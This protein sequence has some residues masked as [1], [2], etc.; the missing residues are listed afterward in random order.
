MI[1]VA[2]A[3]INFRDGS[4][5]AFFE[6]LKS[7]EKHTR[8]IVFLGDIF[9]L[10]IA[11]ARYEKDIHNKF[12]L[13]CKEQKQYRTIGYV[14]GNHE[15]FLAEE[16][17]NY[18]TWCSDKSWYQDDE[19]NVFIHGDQINRHDIKYLFFRKFA[20][21]TAA[22][23]FLKYLPFDLTVF[24]RFKRRLNNT[25]KNFKKVLPRRDILKFPHSTM[26][27]NRGG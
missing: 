17:E 11:F 13:W 23:Y 21:N 1:I 10:W 27:C 6:M 9:D 26:K 7:F 2:D 16:R 22:K 14:E 19:G 18:F 3:H 8:D 5:D 20:R 15:F 4:F 24:E 12:L 25:N